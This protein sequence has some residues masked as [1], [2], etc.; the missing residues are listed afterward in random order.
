M[1]LIA[2]ES[3]IDIA[4]SA[5]LA[6]AVLSTGFCLAKESRFSWTLIYS[7]LGLAVLTK[8]PAAVA[9]YL[10]AVAFFLALTRPGIRE[11]GG[12]LS[13]LKLLPGIALF[14]AVILP[15]HAAVWMQT[16]G[17]FLKVF[18][19]YENVARYAGHTNMGKMSVWFFIP[20]L[21]TGFFPFV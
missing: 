15:W 6:L 2:R 11:L 4:F 3:P 21:A 7:G 10:M 16:E 20:V 1:L 8:G 17:L 5:F 13:R 14:L 12:W 9:L 18:F 19:L